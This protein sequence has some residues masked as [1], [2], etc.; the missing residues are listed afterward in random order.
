LGK[1][2]L[3]NIERVGEGEVVKK[4]GKFSSTEPSCGAFTLSEAGKT[5][6]S[7][8]IRKLLGGERDVNRGCRE[9]LMLKRLL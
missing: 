6:H 7:M 2:G 1:R 4:E 3:G 5:T 9:I 8:E